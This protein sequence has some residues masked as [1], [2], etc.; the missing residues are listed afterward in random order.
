MYIRD[1]GMEKAVVRTMRRVE[2]WRWIKLTEKGNPVRAD[3]LVIIRP[4]LRPGLDAI[5]SF[6]GVQNM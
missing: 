1:R 6:I 4:E 3:S 2:D 5:I